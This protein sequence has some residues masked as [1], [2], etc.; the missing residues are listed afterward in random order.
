VGS[1]PIY[2]PKNKALQRRAFFDSKR[3]VV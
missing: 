2:R 1:N 3:L